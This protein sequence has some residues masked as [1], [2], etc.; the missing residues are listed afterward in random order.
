MPPEFTLS[1]TEAINE[2]RAAMAELPEDM[3]PDSTIEQA[4]FRFAKPWVERNIPENET[5]EAV[6]AAVIAYAAEL[7]FDAW[8]SKSRM[9]DRELEVF[10]QPRVWKDKLEDRTSEIFALYGIS[11]PPKK[12]H[13]TEVAYPTEEA[14]EE[15]LE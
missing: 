6:E 15:A 10:T 1:E 8:F 14:R 11:R 5:N 7:S 9:R 2:V 12:D 4:V 13:I 3:I